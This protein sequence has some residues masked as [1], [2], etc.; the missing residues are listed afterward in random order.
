MQWCDENGYVELAAQFRDPAVCSDTD[1]I[2]VN[3]VVKHYRMQ[4]DWRSEGFGQLVKTIDH[5]ICVGSR[6]GKSRRK[7]NFTTREDGGRMEEDPRTPDR[8]SRQVYNADWLQ[9]RSSAIRES[10]K[11][12]DVQIM[13]E[14]YKPYTSL[15]R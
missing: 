2:E 8:L 10:L 1:E 12:R 9:R 13:T 11:I 14:D 7:K 15:S 5:E 6:I 3:G 4:L